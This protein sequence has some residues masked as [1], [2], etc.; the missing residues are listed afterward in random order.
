M[1]C[2]CVCMLVCACDREPSIQAC[3]Q[4]HVS[5]CSMVHCEE[6]KDRQINQQQCAAVSIHKVLLPLLQFSST[7]R[8]R[9]G[10]VGKTLQLELIV[11]TS[12]YKSQ[13]HTVKALFSSCL[14][15]GCTRG[16]H[17]FNGTTETSERKT[18]TL[19]CVVLVLLMDC[20]QYNE[21]CPGCALF[22]ILDRI[23]WLLC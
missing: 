14:K 10:S 23:R 4:L 7:R 19:L 15:T 21:R 3:T 11:L 6:T 16:S 1:G 17:H 18:L 8:Q 20:V 12:S 13:T 5:S 9:S 22:C 2:V